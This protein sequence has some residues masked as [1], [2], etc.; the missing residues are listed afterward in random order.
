MFI[1]IRSIKIPIIV[2]VFGRRSASQTLHPRLVQFQLCRCFERKMPF[3]YLTGQQ[4][5][6]GDLVSYDGESGTV[7]FT[8]FQRVGDPSVDWYLDE[9]PGGG[10]ML[11]LSSFGSLFITDSENLKLIRSADSDED[12]PMYS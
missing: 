10:V 4:I 5:R 1:F 7:D 8:V 3:T 11:S 9:F 2:D 12:S 6:S